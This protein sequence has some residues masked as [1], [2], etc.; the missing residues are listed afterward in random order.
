MSAHRN[1]ITV[2]AAII[3][4]TVAFTVFAEENSQIDINLLRQSNPF[5]QFASNQGQAVKAMPDGP[6]PDLF[7][8]TVSLKFV[9]AK[10]LK[11][12][13]TTMSGEWGNMEPDAKGNSMIICD[14]NENLTRIIEQI[15]KIDRR[16]DQIMIEVVIL[17][18][19]LNN[20]T[21]IGVNWDML[22]TK[23]NDKLSSSKQIGTSFRQSLGFSSRVASDDSTTLTDATAWNTTGSGSDFSV[24]WGDIRNV[25]HALQ[26]RNNVEILASPRVMVVSG[27]EATIEA[28]EEI[29]YSE[30]S[31]TSSGG[32]LTSTQ[33]KNVGVKLGVGATLTDD[34][35]ILLNI[36]TEQNVQTGTSV[37]TGGDGASGVPVVD[38][39]KVQSSLLL[40]DGQILVI[41]GLRRKETQKRTNQLPILGDL[42]VVG[43]AFKSTDTVQNNSELLVLLSPHIYKGEKPSNAEMDKYN[44]ITKRPLLTIPEDEKQKDKTEEDKKNKKAEKNK[45]TAKINR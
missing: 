37:V 42:P 1:K 24:I 4:A 28:V 13:I 45:K 14:T 29:P 3:L 2:I 17:D 41:G 26:E 30:Q 32:S 35:L 21:E 5:A 15:R 18:V 23:Y 8:E 40:D 6:K 25:I 19:K 20:E 36:N 9:D 31:D 10:S 11:A 34:R 7:I 16:P 43:F 44:E 12:S 27:K 33:F 39:R 22:T 38:T